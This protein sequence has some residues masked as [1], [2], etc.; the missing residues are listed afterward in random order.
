VTN[1]PIPDGLPVYCIEFTVLDAGSTGNSFFASQNHNSIGVLPAPAASGLAS[2]KR[3]LSAHR[4]SAV[5]TSHGRFFIAGESTTHSNGF[6]SNSSSEPDWAEG[7]VL[8]CIVNFVDKVCFFTRNGT[9]LGQSP[10]V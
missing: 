2:E 1:V 7:D 9:V 4:Q 3:A 8:G 6:F 10:L 5:W